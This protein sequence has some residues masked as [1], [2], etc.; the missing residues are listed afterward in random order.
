M[1]AP[2]ADPVEKQG[3]DDTEK[4]FYPSFWALFVRY[5]VMMNLLIGGGMVLIVEPVLS[6]IFR[7][8]SWAEF[9]LHL[10]V[11]LIPTL[12]ALSHTITDV[13]LK[14]VI[15]SPEGLTIR[16]GWWQFRTLTWDDMRDVKRRWV[17]PAEIVFFGF[18]KPRHLAMSLL[19]RD[20]DGF[21][22]A[23]EQHTQADHPLRVYLAN[24]GY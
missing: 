24:R 14:V 23:V 17:F 18:K 1:K 20:M 11:V 13:L 4:V 15:V 5:A 19:L 8:Q 12:V 7:G 9:F 22:R 2:I 3:R 21:A 16:N 6:S 10:F